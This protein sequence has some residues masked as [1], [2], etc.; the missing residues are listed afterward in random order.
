MMENLSYQRSVFNTS[1][2]E[3][4]EEGMEKGMKEGIEKGIEQGIEKGI[5]Q[6]IEKGIEQGQQAKAIQIAKNLLALN[7]PT[8]TIANA[9]GLAAEEIEKLKA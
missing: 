1:R 9:T 2:F 6:G 7:M 4:Y 3:G 8:D 5:E